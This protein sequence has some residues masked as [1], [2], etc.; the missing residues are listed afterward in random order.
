MH[1]IRY[2]CIKHLH[3]IY[4]MCMYKMFYKYIYIYLYMIYMCV[5]SIL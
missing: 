5:R 2:I 1:V 3:R 4:N